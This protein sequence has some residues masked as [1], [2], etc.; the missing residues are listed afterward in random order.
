MKVYKCII[1]DDEPIA[2]DIIISY[3][4]HLPSLTV[5]AT[6]SNA[7][8]AKRVLEESQADI[9]FLDINM[10]VLNGIAFLKTLRHPPQ[11]IFTTAYREYA[12]DAFDL[13]A[14]DYLLKP[15]SLERFIVAVDKAIEKAESVAASPAQ[16]SRSSITAAEPSR[17]ME[18]P[19]QDDSIF[20][21]AEGKIFKL[22]P[23][24]ILYAEASGNYS[25]IITA[26]FTIMPA[27]SFTSL[28]SMLRHPCFSRVHRSF[29]INKQH[30]RLI[31]GNRI[32]I[33]N[34]EIPIGSSYKDDFIK[35]LG[36]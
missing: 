36:L 28:V 27:M 21:K 4:K 8:E 1:V 13:S 7:L 11:V 29:V 12:V 25:K 24:E 14:I 23:D 35:E 19:R 6:C 26:G 30:I 20:L 16:A 18:P 32:F 31:D 34:H 10:P 17:Q 22:V 15:F 9:L 5:Q 2:R 3:C 33:R